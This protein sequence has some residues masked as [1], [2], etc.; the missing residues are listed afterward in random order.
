YD[1]TV[2]PAYGST[3]LSTYSQHDALPIYS[4]PRVH[5]VRGAGVW[6]DAR[7]RPPA[8]QDSAHPRIDRAPSAR[9]RLDNRTAAGGRERASGHRSEE[10]TSELQSR[11]YLVFRL[12]VEKK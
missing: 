2:G 10:H 4:T 9:H 6:P 3:Q 1:H 12:L 7:S 5:P 8:S 11:C